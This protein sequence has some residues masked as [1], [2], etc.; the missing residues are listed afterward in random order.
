MSIVARPTAEAIIS[1]LGSRGVDLTRTCAHDATH[2]GAGLAAAS[3]A[4]AGRVLLSIPRAVWAPLSALEARSALADA[5]VARVDKHAASVGGGAALADATLLASRIAQ[6]DAALQAALGPYLQEL[7]TPDV[8]L[9]WPPPL[10]M[11]LLRGTSAGPAAE[12]QAALSASLHTSLDEGLEPAAFRRAQAILLSRAHSG[13]GKPLA[14]VPG[15]DLLNHGGDDA[16]AAVRFAAAD[17]AF[18][19]VA[20]RD[21]AAGHELLIDYGLCASHRLLRLYGFV[22]HGRTHAAPNGGRA[23]EGDEAIAAE[24]EEAQVPLLPSAAE[25]DGAPEAVLEEIAAA[26]TAL[27]SLGIRGSALRL[28]GTGGGRVVL[29]ALDHDTPAAATARRVL[30]FAVET[31]K[32][33]QAEGAAACTSV[34]M[35]GGDGAA[36]VAARRRAKLCARLHAREAAVLESALAELTQQ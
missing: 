3:A 17:G 26:R 5:A 12:S 28:V 20:T 1:F 8:P 30:R 19:L 27:D 16:N 15:L 9:L 36:E 2:A 18:E 31:Q 6:P 14:L 35:L 33:R 23:S 32:H 29:P 21:V 22:P 25:L 10:R 7:P 11:A 13:D 4:S 34:A 24:G